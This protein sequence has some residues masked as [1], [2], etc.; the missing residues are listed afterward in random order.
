MRAG[1][2]LRL[3]QK[4][5]FSQVYQLKGGLAAWQQASLPLER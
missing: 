1:G 5:Q 2:A 3:L 4:H